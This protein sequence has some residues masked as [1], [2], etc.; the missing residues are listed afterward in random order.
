MIVISFIIQMKMKTNALGK[1]LAQCLDDQNQDNDF[2][3]KLLVLGLRGQDA[4]QKRMIRN[5]NLAQLNKIKKS[6][7]IAHMKIQYQLRSFD[8]QDA[9]NDYDLHVT[10]CKYCVHFND[11]L[12]ERGEHLHNKVCIASDQ[13]TNMLTKLLELDPKITEI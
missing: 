12:C 6:A 11:Y 1:Q 13:K 7:D 9:L 3:T 2:L 4:E 5:L 10:S 8:Q